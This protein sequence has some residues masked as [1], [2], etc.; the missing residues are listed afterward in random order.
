M[1]RLV[2]PIEIV[3]AFIGAL[4]GMDCWLSH[5]GRIETLRQAGLGYLVPVLVL[6]GNS[7]RIHAGQVTHDLISRGASVMAPF[8]ACVARQPDATEPIRALLSLVP[9]PAI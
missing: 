8:A 1:A 6:E 2:I 4:A 9:A 3:N 5:A 7:P